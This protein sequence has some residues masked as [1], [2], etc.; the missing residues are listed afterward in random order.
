MPA[1]ITASRSTS[2][3]SGTRATGGLWIGVAVPAISGHVFGMF[4]PSLMMI[5]SGFCTTTRPVASMASTN[6]CIACFGGYLFGA[7]IVT[8]VACFAIAESMMVFLL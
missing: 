3:G 6:S 2:G 4:G 1:A 5:E 7:M 8:F